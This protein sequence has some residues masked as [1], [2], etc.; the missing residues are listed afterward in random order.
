MADKYHVYPCLPRVTRGYP[1][2][3]FPFAKWIVS[4]CKFLIN[5]NSTFFY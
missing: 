4:V 1:V 5:G 3:C 2:K